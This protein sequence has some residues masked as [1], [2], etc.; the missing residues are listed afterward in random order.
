MRACPRAS[1]FVF[2]L[3]AAAQS[4]R[5]LSRTGDPR[6]VL[7]DK[8]GRALLRQQNVRALRAFVDGTVGVDHR[9]RR[10]Q[11]GSRGAIMGG[12]TFGLLS[13]TGVSAGLSLWSS[14]FP[15]SSR[16]SF[17]LFY[18]VTYLSILSFFK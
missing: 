5:L 12:E 11:V 15:Y 1:W 4:P 7:R 13:E 8:R 9:R 18:A 3:P 17:L 6:R 16:F 10:L 2:H 14:C